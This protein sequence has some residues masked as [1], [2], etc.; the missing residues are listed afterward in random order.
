M[1]STPIVVNLSGWV[2]NLSWKI[3]P[4]GV[5]LLEGMLSPWARSWLSNL[6]DNAAYA[7]RAR[8]RKEGDDDDDD[9][10]GRERSGD[11]DRRR[12]TPAAA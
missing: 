4:V 8:G 12:W 2:E 1:S 7:C 3:S 5:S 10:R 9:A 11:D 6:E